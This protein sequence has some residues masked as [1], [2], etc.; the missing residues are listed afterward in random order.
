MP[1]TKAGEV[2]NL[3]IDYE[4]GR[5]SAGNVVL[6]IRFKMRLGSVELL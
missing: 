4:S 2:T 6:W 5:V 3:E 1:I